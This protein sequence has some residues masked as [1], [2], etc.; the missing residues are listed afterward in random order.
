MLKI[1]RQPLEDRQVTLGRA[2]ETVTFP[3][4][5]TLAKIPQLP[6]AGFELAVTVPVRA[7][8]GDNLSAGANCISGREKSASTSG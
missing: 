1:L 3:A 5:L 7:R 2:S 6:P 8:A 4:S